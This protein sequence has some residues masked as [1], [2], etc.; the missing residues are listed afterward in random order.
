MTKMG[1]VKKGATQL[2]KVIERQLV[3]REYTTSTN[4][5]WSVEWSDVEQYQYFTSLP[6]YKGRGFTIGQ[7]TVKQHFRSGSLDSRITLTPDFSATELD[8]SVLDVSACDEYRVMIEFR[9]ESDSVIDETTWRRRNSGFTNGRKDDLSLDIPDGTEEITVELD[10]VGCDNSRVSERIASSKE[11]WPTEPGPYLTHPAVRREDGIPIFIFS[12][13]T[14]R[15]DHLNH[16]EPLV[17]ALGED[18]IIPEEPRT[19]GHW[20]RP[21]HGSLFTGVHPADHGYVRAHHQGDLLTLSQSLRTLP[22][23]LA[24]HGYKNSSSI[25]REKLGPKFGFGKGFHRGLYHPM[26]WDDRK[27]DISDI[28]NSLSDWVR[29]D[30]DGDSEALFYFTHIFDAHSPYVPPSWLLTRSDLPLD[31]TAPDAFLNLNNNNYLTTLRSDGPEFP[32]DDLQLIEDYYRLSLEY[33]ATKLAEFVSTL[34]DVGLYDQSLLIFIGDHGE[35]FLE[36]NFT[37]HNSL[38]D[39]NIRPGTIVKPPADADFSVPDEMDNIDIFPTI[40]ELLDIPVP[41]QCQGKSWQSHQ[42]RP[43]ITERIADDSYNISVEDD[44]YKAIFSFA[45]EFPTRP[46]TEVIERGPNHTETYDMEQMRDGDHSRQHSIPD[47][48]EQR[49]LEMAN[50]FVAEH[51]PGSTDMETVSVEDD[52]KERLEQLGYK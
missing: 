51:G 37:G 42:S 23:V 32:D 49:L 47:D 35:D 13:D 7:P 5:S 19:Q 46:R 4:L 28:V 18:A 34:K 14:F 40:C 39:H 52:V 10:P 9:D 22:E 30:A 50:R 8:L 26:S 27:Y 41:E 44:G 2:Q 24:E 17:E 43:R 33:V 1:L 12:I 29:A 15:Y 6:T 16:F 20:T 25:I 48:V 38:T 11:Q 3:N 21:A 31:F 36:R 45:D